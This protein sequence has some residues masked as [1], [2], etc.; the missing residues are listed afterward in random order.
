MPLRVDFVLF[1]LS[2]HLLATALPLA[3]L[4]YAFF[5]LIL[6]ARHVRESLLTA[7]H[8]CTIIEPK[9]SH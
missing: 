8:A 3:H 1:D 4:V 5:V 9:D 2:E 7:L 6:L